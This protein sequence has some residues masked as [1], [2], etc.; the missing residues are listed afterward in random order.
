MKALTRLL[1]L[2]A[3]A[4]IFGVISAPHA[5]AQTPAPEASYLRVTEPLD[6]GGTV[7]QP[8]VYVIR[9]LPQTD[10]NLLQVTNEDRSKVFVTVL[11]IPHV[12]GANEAKGN[13]SFVVFPST[14]GSPQALRTWYAPDSTSGG[15]HDIVYPEGRAKKLAAVVKEPVVAYKDETKT[16]ELKTAQL[17]VV[18]PENVV[19]P[20]V[21]PTPTPAPK[22]VM[23]AEAHEMPRTASRVPLFAT[24]GSLLLCVAVGIRAFRAV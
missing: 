24:L 22:P 14:E 16:E 17:E 5:I 6:V 12:I 8:G 20:Y 7:L 3:L 1:V 4:V 23:V 15:G 19:T 11:S 2:S 13:T 18:T 21:A 9:V 10:R